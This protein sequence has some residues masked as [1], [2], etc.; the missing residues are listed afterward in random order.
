MDADELRKTLKRLDA[1]SERCDHL[2]SR[3]RPLTLD[4]SARPRVRPAPVTHKPQATPLFSPD[5]REAIASG[6]L[7]GNEMRISSGYSPRPQPHDDCDPDGMWANF[8][9]EFDDMVAGM[10]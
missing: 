10:H 9:S 6:E 1:M 5:R 8:E 4:T 3:N 7:T 2:I